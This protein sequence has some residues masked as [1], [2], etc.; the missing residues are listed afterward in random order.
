MKCRICGCTEREPCN[1]PCSWARGEGDLCSTCDEMTDS[2]VAWHLAAFKPTLTRLVREV[3][4]R[5]AS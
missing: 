5:L 3:R 1:P 4:I 2:L